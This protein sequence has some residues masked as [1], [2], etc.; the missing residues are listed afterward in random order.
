MEILANT[1]GEILTLAI[2]GAVYLV[3]AFSFLA[4]FFRRIRKTTE[5]KRYFRKDMG[6]K[7]ILRLSAFDVSGADRVF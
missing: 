4:L 5:M 1:S 7:T 3:S 6:S 2:A